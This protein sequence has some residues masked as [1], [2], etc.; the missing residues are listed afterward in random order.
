M[1]PMEVKPGDKVGPYRIVSRL[2]EGGM[3]EVWKARDT[4]LDRDVAIKFCTSQFSSRFLREARAIASLNHPNICTLFDVGQDYLVMEY[5]DGSPPR[6]PLVPRPRL[7]PLTKR[8]S[9]IA[10]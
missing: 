6:G 1:A 4:R 5:I 9:S 8:A 10:I 3:G 2:G 7:K